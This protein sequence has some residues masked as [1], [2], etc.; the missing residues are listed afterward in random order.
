[1]TTINE[2]VVEDAALA[3]LEGLGWQV[4]HGTDIAPDTPGAKRAME[5]AN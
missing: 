1:M 5:V 3:W 2:S 4:A